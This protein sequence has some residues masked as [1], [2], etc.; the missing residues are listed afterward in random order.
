VSVDRGVAAALGAA[1]LFGLSTP[2]AKTL[3]GDMPPLLLAGLLYLGSGLGLAALLLGRILAGGR[4][5]ITWP[6]GSNLWWLLGAIIAGGMLGPYFLMVG[7]RI[8][9]SASATLILNLEGVL[10]ALLAWFVFKENFDRRI[11]LGMA[12]IVAGGAVLSLGPTLRAGGL[13]GPLAIAGACLAWAVDNNLTRKVSLHD[14]MLIACTKGLAAGITSVALAIALGAQLPPTPSVLRACLLGF[15]GYGLSLTLFVAALRRLGTARTG[16]Y[17]S[18]GPFIGAGVAVLLGAPPTV[19]LAIAGLLMGAG[20]WL[21][22]SEHHAHW[23]RHDYL[24][25]EHSHSHDEHHQHLHAADW[26]R[27]EPHSHAHIHE[28]LEHSHA[29]YPDIHHRHGH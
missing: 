6:R 3:V 21:H 1:I 29:H 5:R 23:H 22:L 20:V 27:S 7:L 2:L 25:H 19:T 4:A 26:D 13:L 16:A 15:V 17:F 11:A 12:L 10:T 24:E 28:P 8:T 18:L 9:D 14:A